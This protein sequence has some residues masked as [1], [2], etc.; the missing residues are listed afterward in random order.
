[1]KLRHAAIALV[2][3][4]IALNGDAA[5]RRDYLVIEDFSWTPQTAPR[6]DTLN[7]TFRV[8]NSDARRHDVEMFVAIEPVHSLQDGST[9]PSQAGCSGVID[10]NEYSESCSMEGVSRQTMTIGGRESRTV[11][12]WSWSV[13]RLAC[14][15]ATMQPADGDYML[16][17]YVQ[18]WDQTG[19]RGRR[20]AASDSLRKPFHLAGADL[21]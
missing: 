3:S 8:T 12:W 1:M 13:A 9:C 15:P 19:R 21:R 14:L 2:L 17:V 4:M 7:F 5:P 18:E 10:I 6:G 16:A 11:N 20:L